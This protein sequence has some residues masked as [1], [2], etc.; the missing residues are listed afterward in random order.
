MSTVSQPI[1]DN[2]NF[3]IF[4]FKPLISIIILIITFIIATIISNKVNNLNV[5]KN[6]KIVMSTISYIVYYFIILIGVLISLLNI[7]F[8]I[9]SMIVILSTLGA[10]IA[11]GLQSTI[12]QLMSGLGIVFN[13]IYNLN[14]Y[15]ITNGIEGTVT[16]F[17]LFTT[18]IIDD[19]DLTITIPND[20]IANSNIIN[21]TNKNIIRIHVYF[22]IKNITDF[23]ISKFIELVK[24]TTLLSKY[25][26]NNNIDVYVETISHMLGT[27]I[28]VKAYINSK[29]YT[30]AKYN[31]KYLLL[32]LLSNT[33]LLNSPMNI[34]YIGNKLSGN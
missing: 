19:D 12:S 14:D 25:I 22:T 32:K 1:V 6:K 30:L 9:G 8:Q 23:N 16:A 4:K 29:D 3:N 5:K 26:I 15:I 10:A 17:S 21:V 2:I 27:K 7:G 28:V 31:I 20:K 11:L 33:K 13:N 34:T 18:T 24:K